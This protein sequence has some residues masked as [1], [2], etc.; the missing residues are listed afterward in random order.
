MRL[1][2]LLLHDVYRRD[3]AESGFRSAAADRYKLPLDEFDTL[4]GALRRVWNGAAVL[5]PL[6]PA[7]GRAGFAV[8]VDDGGESF[9]SVIAD[10]LEEFDWRGHCFVCTGAIGQPGFL[11]RRQ[12]ADLDRRG[13]VIGAHSVTHPTRFSA[14]SRAKMLDEWRRSRGTLEDVLG[15]DVRTASLPG[16]F[17][18]TRAAE[19][20]GEAGL[21]VLFTSEPT[22]VSYAVGPCTV[23]GRLTVRRG[24]DPRAVLALARGARAAVWREQVSWTAKKAL[25][26][27]LGPAYP[28]FGHWAAARFD[29]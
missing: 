4:L 10:R 24:R 18:S 5:A 15:R 20:A 17:F 22:L 27:M 7:A 28:R 11:D 6:W 8:T 23:V 14:C 26:S 21:Q 29:R 16:G 12:L 19:T 9:H 2:S 1:V 25:R 13:H 3:P